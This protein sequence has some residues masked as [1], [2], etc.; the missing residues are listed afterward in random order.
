MGKVKLTPLP[1]FDAL[2]RGGRQWGGNAK[3]YSV[4]VCLQELFMS[5]NGLLT[6]LTMYLISDNPRHGVNCAEI[7]LVGASVGGKL[8]RQGAA[9]GLNLGGGT[10][11]GTRCVT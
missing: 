5:S 11:G 1:P 7:Y 9:R 10:E 6:V 2:C 4:W 3:N 8:G